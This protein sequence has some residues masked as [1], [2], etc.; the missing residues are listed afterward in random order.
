MGRKNTKVHMGGWSLAS[1]AMAFFMLIFGST[2]MVTEAA[3][4]DDVVRA[5]TFTGGLVGPDIP[6]SG[7]VKDGGTIVAKTAP[8]CWGPMITPKFKGGH[9]VTQPVAVEGAEVGD[10]VV[11]RIKKIKVTSLAT[12][13]GV[14]EA[15][16]G[17]FT[18]DPFVARKCPGCGAESPET[19]VEG[20]GWQA[21][22]CEK[23]GASA[24]PF[25]MPHGYTMVF[26]DERS[27]GVTVGKQT[28]ETIARDAKKYAAL[29]ANSEQHSILVFGKH[30]IPGV[31]TRLRPM[32]GNIGTTPPITMPDSHNCGDFGQFLVGAPHLYGIN[33]AQ[34]ELRT[35]GHLDIDS[36][37]EGAILIC[38]VKVD[39]AGIYIGDVHAMQGDGEIAVHTTDVSAE[40]TVQVELIK[41]LTI[42]GP[43][44][45]PPE[46]DLPLL[47]KP[48]SR[49]EMQRAR[50]LAKQYGVE[51]DE[52]APIQVVGSGGD[53][54]TA[55]GNG[56]ERTAKLLGMSDAEVRNRVTLTGSVEIGRAPGL[57][58]ISIM[59]PVERLQKLGIYHLVKEQY[60]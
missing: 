58:T 28:A 7:P 40:V 20:I 16:E 14:H 43:I 42:D 38:P 21:I 19:Y 4:A 52:V 6:M 23:C 59:V 41:G 1:V 60:G 25:K 49:E 5:E 11:I 10:A 44:L 35:D 47:A 13:V 53:L 46:E 18:G 9:E 26:A 27:L 55:V 36:V 15:I 48:L 45:L 34:K 39:G 31:V 22:K 54:T 32:I 8:G 50:A 17:T 30:D 2:S 33:Q 57:I 3:G 29:P 51:L 24:C 12:S 37:R 56:L